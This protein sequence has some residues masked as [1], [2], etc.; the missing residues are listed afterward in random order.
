MKLKKYTLF[1]LLFSYLLGS[2]QVMNVRKWRKSEKDSL[3]N[4]MYLIDELQYLQA[5]PIFD[6]LLKNHPKEEFLRYTYAKCALYR[7]DKHEDAYR[8]LTE[9]YSKNSS[10]PDVQF[11]IALAAHYNYKF[12]EAS[13]H[14]QTFLANR[15]LTPE[16]KRAAEQLKIYIANA[17]KIYNAPTDAKLKVLGPEMNSEGDETNPLITADDSRLVYTYRGKKSLGG[18]QN[19]YLQPD[20]LGNYTGD[21]YLSGKVAGSFSLSES[22][23][24]LNTNAND[25]ALALSPDGQQLFLYVDLGDGHGDIYQS[26]LTGNIFGAPVKLRGEINSYSR[27]TACSISPDGKTIYFSSDRGGGFGGFDL[28]KA[29]LM[30]DSSWSNVSNLGDSINTP[31]D[32]DMPFMHADGRSLYYSSNGMGSMGGFDIFRAVMPANDS[33]FRRGKNLGYPINTTFDDRNF[34][35]S[36]DS[37]Q[38]YYNQARKE[39]YGGNDLYSI[40]TNFSEPSLPFL[41][42]KGMTLDSSQPVAAEITVELQNQ[43]NRVY[44]KFQSNVA[45]GEYLICLPAGNDYR[46][47]FH[48]KEKEDV[49]FVADAST[50]ETY[51]E[52]TNTVDFYVVPPVDLTAILPGGVTTTTGSVATTSKANVASPSPSPAP[53]PTAAP[54]AVTN[55]A[56]AKEEPKSINKEPLPTKKNPVAIS[57]AATAASSLSALRDASFP[58]NAMQE[59]TLRFVEKYGT[60][61]ADGLE[62]RVQ[63]A[64]VKADHNTIFP[65]QARL[66]KIDKIDLQDGF[67]RITAGGKFSNMAKALEHNRK[68]VKAGVGESFVVA[69]YKGQKV[70]YEVL[71][72][73]GIFK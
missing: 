48:Y 68:V 36:A 67:T 11:D 7:S 9:L 18:V 65:N 62:F 10:I 38:G 22:I 42:V 61:T 31:F 16:E 15:N 20:P 26:T 44:R 5:L 56:I 59:K 70:N 66:G 69:I 71:E 25:A 23:Q 41:L 45:T 32:E 28:Y 21:L 37:R 1:F 43:K 73:Q 39:G 3:D 54:A 27:E 8:F 2:A 30:K 12:D 13:T 52:K 33:L 35:L 6:K 57:P 58:I 55:S 40:E 24:N 53:S 17:R 46:L 29:T 50:I 64:A 4:A 34:V 14:L 19:N 49:F 63:L 51:T 60:I 47:V 72:Q